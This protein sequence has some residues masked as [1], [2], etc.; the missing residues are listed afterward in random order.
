[1]EHLG[2]F[3]FRNSLRNMQLQ[4]SGFE[5]PQPF[6]TGTTVVGVVFDEGVMIG[7]DSRGTIKNLIV[8]E[9]NIKL[10]KLQEHIY[11]GGTGYGSDLINLTAI[12]KT[13]LDMHYW[14]TNKRPVPVVAVKKIIREMVLS[15]H[16][17][18]MAGYIIG[19]VDKTGVHL[20]TVY[21]DGSTDNSMYC[22]MGSGQYAAM[23]LLETGWQSN[24]DEDDA[25]ELMVKAIKAGITADAY[26]GCSIDLCIIRKDFTV[27]H[28]NEIISQSTSSNKSPCINPGKAM[29]RSFIVQE[30][31]IVSETVHLLKSNTIIKMPLPRRILLK[32]LRPISACT[33]ISRKRKRTADPDDTTDESPCKKKRD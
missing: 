4:N 5:P 31:E 6:I 27:E 9:E 30:L 20:C 8:C 18:F 22:S 33:K 24:M 12:I 26:S 15:H 28:C 23:G 11:C 7:T 25:R 2:G 17:K 10:H 3:N 29:V 13:Q 21:F 32:S 14:N 16:G 19:G 1:M